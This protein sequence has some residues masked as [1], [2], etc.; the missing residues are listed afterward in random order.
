[1]VCYRP[2]AGAARGGRGAERKYSGLVERDAKMNLHGD[3]AESWE[4]PDALTYVFRLKK[5]MKFYDGREVTSKDVKTTFDYIMNPA[6]KSP[7]SGSFRMI[8]SIEAPDA[9]TV[10]FRLKEPYA[11]FLWNLE[12]SAAEIVPEDERAPARD[13]GNRVVPCGWYEFLAG[14]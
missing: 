10:V 9:Y 13:G 4:T 14:N 11:S 1:V 3:L 6:N 5:G 12:K 7:K 8:A 2:F